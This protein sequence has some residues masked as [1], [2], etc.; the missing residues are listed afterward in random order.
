MIE[1][2]GL[3]LRS[4]TDADIPVLTEMRNDLALQA[5]LLARPRGSSPAQVR[6]WLK[7]RTADLQGLLLVIADSDDDRT[8]GYVQITDIHAIDQRGELGM[9][10]H[11]RAQGQ[12]LGSRALAL[13]P[14]YLRRVWL[15]RKL[16]LRVRADN[17]RAIACYE[18]A[19]FERCGLLREHVRIDGALRDL[20]LM[21]VFLH[22]TGTPCA[23]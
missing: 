19:G 12:H 3:R 13:L 6:Q 22:E 7:E 5:E 20:V 15:L 10:L 18:K 2:Q 14:P 21:E 16:T 23:S 8:L 4:W 1:G 11:P 9:C 17:L